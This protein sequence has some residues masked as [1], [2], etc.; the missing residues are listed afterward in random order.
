M[1]NRHVIFIVHVVILVLMTAA[2]YVAMLIN[3]GVLFK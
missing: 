3:Q 2:V 1:R